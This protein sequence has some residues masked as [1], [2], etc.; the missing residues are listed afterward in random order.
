MSK[1]KD[2][3]SRLPDFF[4]IGL[5]IILAVLV[6][7]VI[8][9]WSARCASSQELLNK[10][11]FVGVGCSTPWKSDLHIRGYVTD[12]EEDVF[13]LTY[14][15][16]DELPISR[17][18][19]AVS[20]PDFLLSIPNVI[21]QYFPYREDTSG[22]L[23][24]E[25]PFFVRGW[26]RTYAETEEGTVGQAI[27]RSAPLDLDV[28]Y[29]ILGD[30]AFPEN[31][32]LNVFLV[33][34]DSDFAVIRAHDSMVVLEERE[35]YLLYN[36]PPYVILRVEIGSKVHAIASLVDNGTSDP[37]TIPIFRVIE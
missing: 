37:T 34:L 15:A 24:I 31:S 5:G 28:N 32:R 21:C 35:A 3:S 19:R 14:I 25:S 6:I 4:S 30:R 10:M 18:V 11:T 12:P 23:I 36:L 20:Y 9:S 16:V 26:V 27:P 17:E 2:D 29:E 8:M 7:A 33:N 1:N 13:V 22:V